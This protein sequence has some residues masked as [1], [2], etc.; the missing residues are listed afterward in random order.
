MGQGTDLSRRESRSIFHRTRTVLSNFEAGS[1]TRH[2]DLPV[3]VLFKVNDDD[4]Y[5][6]VDAFDTTVNWFVRRP[7]YRLCQSL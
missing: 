7:R 2:Q 6:A 3:T 1:T 5:L 4:T